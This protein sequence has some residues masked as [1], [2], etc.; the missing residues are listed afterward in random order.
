MAAA[1]KKIQILAVAVLS[2]ASLSHAKLP[3]TQLN[4]FRGARL[5][6]R[7]GPNFVSRLSLRGGSQVESNQIPEQAQ[8]EEEE[9]KLLGL[10][11]KE[12]ALET[13]ASLLQSPDETNISGDDDLQATKTLLQKELPF[14][15][16]RPSTE[17]SEFKYLPEVFRYLTRSENHDAKVRVT[18]SQFC[19][20]VLAL[21]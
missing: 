6:L 5:Y 8:S 19:L 12:R 13:G 21:V 11:Q 3:A 9:A 14:L 18:T 15:F 1:M 7:P 10:L 20:K 17:F 16:K 4:S 2:C